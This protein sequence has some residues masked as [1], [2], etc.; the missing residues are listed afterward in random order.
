MRM[1]MCRRCDGTIEYAREK[2]S[3]R[4]PWYCKPC[5]KAIEIDRIQLRNMADLLKRR[6]QRNPNC[7]DCGQPLAFD[8]SG[9]RRDMHTYCAPCRTARKRSQDSRRIGPR[10][11]ATKANQQEVAA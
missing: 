10:L 1:F 5:V 4:L 7:R 9:P 11:R 2:G 8:D 3:G 6:A